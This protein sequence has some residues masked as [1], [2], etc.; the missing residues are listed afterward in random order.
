[1]KTCQSEIARLRQQIALEYEA[2]HSGLSGFAS[3]AARHDFIQAKT[4]NI[5]RYQDRKSV[6]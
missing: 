2:A 1:M 5:G 3:G 4:E 6:V